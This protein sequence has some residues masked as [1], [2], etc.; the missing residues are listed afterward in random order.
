MPLFS[1]EMKGVDRLATSLNDIETRY[2]VMLGM[3]KATVGG[4]DVWPA[5]RMA[6]NLDVLQQ[7]GIRRILELT[8]A[9][10]RD[11]TAGAFAP[12]WVGGRA[13]LEMAALMYDLS[14]RAR[15]C[16][17]AP[18]AEAFQTLDTHAAKIYLGFK[19]MEWAY[20]EDVKAKNIL[21][22]VQKV[23]KSDSAAYRDAIDRLGVKIEKFMGIYDLLS[24]G[25]HPNYVGTVDAYQR[26]G[27]TVGV[28]E[29]ID[30]PAKI[31]PK[32][33]AQPVDG[34]A[35]A[36]SMS[37]SAVEIWQNVRDAFIG[38]LPKLQPPPMPEPKPK[39]Q[40]S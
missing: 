37:V 38:L 12:V 27:A 28:L 9:L 21:T 3:K 22:T 39:P 7:V 40:T 13:L 26:L 1:D 25:A 11:V 17:D 23:S 10:G 36:L 34:A 31:D 30:S 5:S 8:E 6:V 35:I 2:T 14:D 20:S 24:E 4:A 16:V 29:L 32:R 19:S 15:A 18:T 33:I